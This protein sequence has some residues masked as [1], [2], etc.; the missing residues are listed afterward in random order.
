MKQMIEKLAALERTIATEKGD[1]SL[2]ALLLREDAADKWDLLLAAPWLETDK[3]DS[4]AYVADKLRAQL[5]TQQLLLLSRI[6]ILEKG[7]PVLEALHRMI[8]VQHGMGEVRDSSVFGVPI[9]QAY[10]ITS[11]EES[12][13]MAAAPQPT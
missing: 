9:K 12:P 8:Q 2:F 3:K 1:L 4:L 11:A 6:V 13:D 7:N 10:L 5:T